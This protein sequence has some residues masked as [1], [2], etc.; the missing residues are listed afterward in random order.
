MCE[1]HAIQVDPDAH[2]PLSLRALPNHHILLANREPR[3]RRCVRQRNGQPEELRVPPRGLLA[4]AAGGGFVGQLSEGRFARVE[5]ARF[6]FRELTWSDPEFPEI[7]CATAPAIW[8]LVCATAEEY[9]VSGGVACR[10]LVTALC[11]Q[12]AERYATPTA[13]PGQRLPLNKRQL[14]GLRALVGSELSGDL[15]VD[16]LA[17]ELGMSSS[18]FT[19]VFREVTGKTPHQWVIEIR[20]ERARWLLKT[21]PSAIS[22]VASTCG[23]SDQAHLT[24]LFKRRFGVTPGRFRR[25]L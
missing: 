8:H 24:R 9:D 3:P 15:S 25:A 12:M 18:Y 2:G 11:V 1:A 16:R 4:I 17:N 22:E 5:L 19:K 13:R 23:F 14:E 10:A 7:V 6:V 21:S 20:L